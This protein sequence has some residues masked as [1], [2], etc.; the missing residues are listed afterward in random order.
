MRAILNVAIYV[1]YSSCKC[2]Y[3][4]PGKRFA[5]TLTGG[6][7]CMAGVGLL[8]VIGPFLFKDRSPFRFA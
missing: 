2:R 5:V 1:S 7:A 3:I 8:S 6:V 4:S